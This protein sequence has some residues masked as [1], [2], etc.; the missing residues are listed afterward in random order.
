MKTKKP[1]TAFQMRRECA[2]LIQRRIDRQTCEKTYSQIDVPSG[3]TEVTEKGE[4]LGSISDK[5]LLYALLQEIKN[6]R[7]WRR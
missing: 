3:R 5:Q 6:T 2:A 7:T 1:L 4:W